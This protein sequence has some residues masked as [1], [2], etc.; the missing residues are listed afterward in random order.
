MNKKKELKAVDHSAVEYLPIRKNLYTVPRDLARMSQDDITSLRAKLG[1]RVRGKGAPPPAESFSQCGV[2]ER[3][4]VILKTKL[5]PP[6]RYS[7]IRRALLDTMIL[8]DSHR[9][10]KPPKILLFY[11]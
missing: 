6:S 9:G 4:L 1:I 10:V 11:L 2:S 7:K 3:I 5:G 8:L